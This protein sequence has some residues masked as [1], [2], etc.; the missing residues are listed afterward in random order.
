MEDIREKI[1]ISRV[2][3]DIVLK[4]VQAHKGKIDLHLISMREE[5][6]MVHAVFSYH[7]FGQSDQILVL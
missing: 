1:M 7:V 6:Y 3:K 2:R 4:A 5:G